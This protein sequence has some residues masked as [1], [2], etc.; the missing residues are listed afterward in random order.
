M[1][2][3]R[4]AHSLLA[5]DFSSTPFWWRDVVPLN[6]GDSQLP[7]QTDALIVGSGY[8]GLSCAME[9]AEAGLDV[10]VV[11]THDIGSGA[12]SRAAG[13][14]SGRASIS[15]F[16]NLER[17]FGLQ[18]ANAILEEADEAYE[19]FKTGL[20]VNKIDC[21]FVSNGRFVGAHTPNAFEKLSDKVAE[22]QR[23]GRASLKMIPRAEQHRFVKSDYF[24]GGMLIK[25][26]GLV[27]PAKYHA[28]L[29]RLCQQAGVRLVGQT[30]AETV[31]NAAEG[32]LVTT[33]RGSI[34]A[35]EVMIGTGGYT[36]RVS[37][38]HRRRII[39]VS[40]TIIATERLDAERVRDLLPAGSAV[41]DS[42]RVIIF[43]RPSPDGH[44][45]LFGGRARFRPLSPE[46][47]VRILHEQMTEVFPDLAD[48]K[49]INTWS[50]LMA[51]TFDFLPKVGVHDGV[52]YAMACNGGAGIVMM[53]WLGRKAAQKILGTANRESAFDGLPFRTQPFY[54]GNPWFIPIVGAWYQFRDW[55]ELRQARQ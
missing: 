2:R 4:S 44:H 23:E 41:I 31:T 16:V 28:G 55:V 53:S 45:I 27:H 40:S 33:T 51:F 35:R 9:L 49:V 5:D 29:V 15:K 13:F 19:H 38:W 43:A 47:S 8:A 42:K 25:D 21:D 36:D 17:T 18:R 10:T 39:P 14:T 11:D 30:R 24:Y 7:D 26:A 48:V 54:T 3:S 32:K 46:A 34:R 50:G 12:S 6:T 1:T 20:T 22:I 52:H 37:R